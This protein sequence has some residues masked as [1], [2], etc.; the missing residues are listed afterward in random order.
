MPTPAYSHL[1]VVIEENQNFNEIVGNVSQAPFINSLMAGAAN[2]VNFNAI[3]HPSQPN[4]FAL[5]AG[6]TF[7]TTHHNQYS[8]PGQTIDT[9][10][11]GAG[12]GFT[13]YVSEGCGG[14]DFNRGPSGPAG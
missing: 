2:M 13:G 1:V 6:S 12:P 10:L 11:H 9:I 8:E 4:Y 7:G 3:T 14:S 5:Y